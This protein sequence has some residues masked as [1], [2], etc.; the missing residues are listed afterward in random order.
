MDLINLGSYYFTN[1]LI[2]SPKGHILVDAGN[3]TSYDKFCKKL[4]RKGVLLSD[5]KYLII[6]HTH[7]DHLSYLADFLKNNP[8]VRCICS[9]IGI[10]R[11]NYEEMVVGD[12]TTALS[13]FGGKMK[14][15]FPCLQIPFP[16]AEIKNPVVA[17]ENPDYLIEEGYPIKLVYLGGHSDDSIGFL[18]EDKYFFVGD[19]LFQAPPA[20]NLTPLVIEDLPQF[21]KAIDLLEKSGAELFYVGHGTPIS[22]KKLKKKLGKIYKTTLRKL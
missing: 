10:E 21:F 8:H 17:E 22:M 9:K 15:K 1:Y 19:V 13:R 4:R 2:R 7:D 12:Y 18:V 14:N 3:G 6:T 16:K 11:A 20:K 5:I